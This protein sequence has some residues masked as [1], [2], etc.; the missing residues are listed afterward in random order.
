ML[1]GFNPWQKRV[2]V[3]GVMG[4]LLALLGLL[5]PWLPVII[6]GIAVAI[7]GI[8]LLVLLGNRQNWRQLRSIQRELDRYPVQ[9]VSSKA[10]NASNITERIR[11]LGADYEYARRI[12]TNRSALESFAL[13]SKSLKIRDAFAL[14]A[15]EE[16]LNFDDLT[17]FI[18]VQRMKMLPEIKQ[19][20]MQ[21]WNQD[22]LI[23]LARL[24]ANQQATESD[25]EN[26]AR[27]F[28][29]IQTFFG[30]KALR[31]NDR[32][33]FL[34]V[35][36][37]LG[38]YEQQSSLARR[39][40]V[41]AHFPVQDVLLQ[42]NATR[43]TSGATSPTWLADLNAMYV[44]HG[45][46]PV[47][48]QAAQEAKPLD[49]L[50]T[51]TSPITDGP[52]ISV[53]VPTY[54]GGPLLLSALK[55]LLNQSWQNLEIIVVDDGSGPDYEPYLASAEELSCKIKVLRQKEN[56][57]A[58][59]ARNAGLR[60][61]T[62]E[63]ITVHDDDDWSHGDKLA[64]QVRHLIENSNVPGNMSA[65][66]R[67]TDDLK[68]LRINNNPILSQ[69]N[70]SSLMVHKSIFDQ[71][72]PWDTVNRGGDSEFRDRLV[73]Y[74]EQPVEVL[75]KVPLS[76]TRTWEGSLT[77][78]EMSRG[79][80]DPSRLLYLDAYTQYHETAKEKDPSLIAAG[81]RQFPV[82]TT[83]EPGARKKDLGLFDVVFMTDFRFPGGTTSLTLKEIET[84]HEAGLR[85]GFIQ[86]DSPLNA[87]G[88]PI[89]RHLLN[90]QLN[91]TVVQISMLDSADINLLLIRHPSV[92]NFL[93]NASTNLRITTP[94][95]I[96]NNP[97]VLTGG[98]GMVFDLTT[99]LRNVDRLLDHRTVVVAES[100]VTK[101]LCD[102]LLPENRL[103]SMTWPGLIPVN[104]SSPSAPEFHNTP[105]L[106]RHSRDHALKW[107]ST[108][109]EFT[110]AYLSPTFHTQILGGVETLV[111]KHGS[112]V[113]DNVTVY[114][115][116][117]KEVK[118]FL[119]GIDFWVYFHDDK[120]RE[121][122]G[123]SIAEAMAS[124]KVVILPPYLASTF[125]EGA[126]YATPAEVESIVRGY[127]GD[128]AKYLE[129]SAR[130]R[131]YVSQHF[132]TEAF[133][134]RLRELTQYHGAQK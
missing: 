42:L 65:H 84:A 67:V 46:S 100:G 110:A 50:T 116:G 49:K 118:D 23:A 30:A 87:V 18:S 29:F 85:V 90:L 102:T 20:D 15:T 47:E 101:Q 35:L 2:T 114:D 123:M 64:T 5:G 55:S 77:S 26:A 9:K 93:D 80:V 39:F 14:A 27:M 12:Q 113:T 13:R 57:G 133:I 51:S 71:I 86:A 40:D 126:L 134:R 33:I 88:N 70:F 34:E 119:S 108:R 97:P 122:F 109:A 4:V 78:G 104:G 89:S 6:G 124:G 107:P 129:Q 56:L 83:M 117:E 94:V 120:L 130:A 45:F 95:L 92:V 98:T 132:S 24:Q 60:A 19:R 62:G 69:A 59:C 54:Q 121:S 82:P 75:N 111:D 115:F 16:Q 61:A 11:P 48:M 17:R 25:L 103:M 128:P 72:G 68:F 127:W 21:H 7:S 22:A 3:L 63:Y 99:C 131:N 66:V 96:V 73:K 31:R 1:R 36:G 8:L 52:R 32:L 79:F 106:G 28:A 43:S 91:G 10:A 38:R 37:E 125:G 76:F 53:I 44:R 74:S 58:Y 41:A 112:D 81:V 105:I